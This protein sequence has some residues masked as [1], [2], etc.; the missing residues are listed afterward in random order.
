MLVKQAK[1]IDKLCPGR[2]W[3]NTLIVCKQSRNPDA[4]SMGAKMAAALISA[5]MNPNDVA[6]LGFTYLHDITLTLNQR[7]RLVEDEQMRKDFL[8]LTES[9][10]ATLVISAINSLPETIRV[11]FN[12][13][14]CLDCGQ[15]GDARLMSSYCHM[16]KMWEHPGRVATFHPGKLERYHDEASGV[17]YEHPGPLTRPCN[18]MATLF[19]CP[20]NADRYKCCGN[21]VGSRGC[22]EKRACCRKIIN[23][24]QPLIND[25]CRM[26][27]SCCKVNVQNGFLPL[28]KGCQSRYSCCY[29][30]L[31]SPGCQPKCK[32]CGRDWGSSPGCFEKEHNLVSISN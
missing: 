18:L 32:K 17:I 22:V 25:G 14:M 23:E 9:E 24:K 8:V 10:V 4:D 15:R 5:G 29:A 21:F 16:E 20:T 31:K 11:I 19:C 12:D 30:K 6:A 7:K 2:I 27:Y 28:I 1:L 26:R 13:Q 3:R